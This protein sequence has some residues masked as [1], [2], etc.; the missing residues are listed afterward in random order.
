MVAYLQVSPN[1]VPHE[2]TEM[3][4]RILEFYSS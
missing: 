4:V 2:I 3:G 1:M